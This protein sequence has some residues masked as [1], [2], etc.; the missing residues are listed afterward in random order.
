MQ[1]F[2]VLFKSCLLTHPLRGQLIYRQTM[3][4]STETRPFIKE[5]YLK[6]FQ[7]HFF[8][9]PQRCSIF[10]SGHAIFSVHLVIFL[11]LVFIPYPQVRLHALHSVHSLTRQT[12]SSYI[13]SRRYNKVIIQRCIQDGCSLRPNQWKLLSDYFQKPFTNHLHQLLLH[14]GCV[15]RVL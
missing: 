6:W 11:V 5:S 13:G 14:K 10:S 8:I 2:L 1:N 4:H 9:L 3:A 15:F 7:L 12:F